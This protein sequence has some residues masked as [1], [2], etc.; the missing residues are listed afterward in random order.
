MYVRVIID[1][2]IDGTCTHLSLKS[3]LCILHKS[4]DIRQA[5]GSSYLTQTHNIS[6]EKLYFWGGRKTISA[7]L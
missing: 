1:Q 3:S 4:C 5:F 7:L 2:S 6:Q